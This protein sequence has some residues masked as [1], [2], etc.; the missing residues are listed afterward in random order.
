M[1]N[2]RSV[3]GSFGSRCQSS[4]KYRNAHHINCAHVCGGGGG[5]GG[6]GWRGGVDGDGEGKGRAV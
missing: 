2:S 5:G 1:V 3:N 6:S 4:F